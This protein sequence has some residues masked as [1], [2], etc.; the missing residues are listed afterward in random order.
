L[1]RI[2]RF[3]QPDIIQTWLY[4]ADLLGGL[5]GRLAWRAPVVWGLHHT[6]TSTRTLKP[7]TRLVVRINARLSGVLPQRIVCCAR[8][9][10][11][12]HAQHGFRRDR[13]VVIPNGIDTDRFRPDAQARLALRSELHLAPATVLIGGFARF[14]PQKDHR[15]LIAAAV[16]LHETLPGA[17]FVLA[18]AGI[19]DANPQLAAWIR[20]AGLQQYVHM[21]GVR[22]DM[23]ALQ[24][25]MDL[26]TLTAVEGEALPLVMAEAMACG[27]PCV[28]T[29]VGDVSTMIG[30]TGTCVAPGDPDALALAWS[31]MLQLP[32][33]ERAALGQAARRRVLSHYDVRSAA[34]AYHDLYDVILQ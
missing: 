25:A 18:G 20:E 12:T 24:A 13:L 31:A 22:R 6:L 4:H 3:F 15:T 17:H 34:R 1:V 30:E 9:A 16:I 14:H 2:I 5:C 7:A 10:L 29:S 26:C 28:A 27:V 33:S 8:S 23:P 11:E 32:E 19:E 21:L